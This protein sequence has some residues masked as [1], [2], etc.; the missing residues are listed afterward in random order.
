MGLALIF[1]AA[2]P[3]FQ[4]FSGLNRS[5]CVDINTNTLNAET[6]LMKL[7]KLILAMMCLPHFALAQDG[8]GVLIRC[9]ASTGHGFFFRDEV[10][11]PSGPNWA[12]DG[13]SKGKIILIKLGDEWDIQFDDGI[14][15]YGYRQDGA[16]VI[17]LLNKPGMIT[18]GAFNANYADLYTFDFVGKKVAWSSNKLG[19]IVAKVAAY[20]ADC[21]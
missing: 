4:T 13:M 5:A 3:P 6:H 20:S 21:E 9:G 8:V 19:P 18:V 10:N 7:T 1:K 16:K 12:E 15:A 14:G 11:N 2:P 17:P